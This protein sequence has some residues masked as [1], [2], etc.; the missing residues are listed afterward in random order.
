MS[1]NHSILGSPTVFEHILLLGLYRVGESVKSVLLSSCIKMGCNRPPIG[2]TSSTRKN[3]R[4]VES[5]AGLKR[6]GSYR[7]GCGIRNAPT[8]QAGLLVRCNLLLEWGGGKNALSE[9]A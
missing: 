8:P 5:E 3:Y 4:G 2:V 1:M 9:A 6:R 7:C